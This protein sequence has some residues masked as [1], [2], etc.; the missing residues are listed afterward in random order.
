MVRITTRYVFA[1][2]RHWHFWCTCNS[3]Q[4]LWG[5]GDRWQLYPCTSQHCSLQPLLPEGR[6]DASFSAS[7]GQIKKLATILAQWERLQNLPPCSLQKPSGP[8]QLALGV[9]T[10][11]GL[12]QMGTEVSANLSHS[13]DCDFL[14]KLDSGCQADQCLSQSCP[15]LCWHSP[16]HR[17]SCN[18]FPR[19]RKK[20]QATHPAALPE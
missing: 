15:P 7:K 3:W 4:K 19:R 1:T 17:T 10:G 18:R 12:E 8:G 11:S 20:K 2:L 9:P 16:C 6:C 13:V 5:S 14:K